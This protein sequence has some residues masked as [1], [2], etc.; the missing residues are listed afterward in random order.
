MPT[1]LDTTV[2]GENA[3]SYASLAE[4]D[5][6]FADDPNRPDPWDSHSDAQKQQALLLATKYI[7]R[8]RLQGTALDGS[9]ALRFPTSNTVDRQ[10]EPFI[11][12]AIKYAQIEWAFSIINNPPQEGIDRASL[13]AQGVVSFARGS[14]REVLKAGSGLPSIPPEVRAYL[15]P[16][17]A[18][19]ARALR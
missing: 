6:Y 10:G 12:I 19:G 2:G 14:L 3:N 17:L 8:L 18:A 5:I 1:P 13:Q 16:W 15:S 9:Q 11:P 7:E 4:A